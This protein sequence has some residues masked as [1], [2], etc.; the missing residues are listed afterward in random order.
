M[1]NLLVL[2]L[3]ILSG[4]AALLGYALFGQCSPDVVV[5]TAAVAV[6]AMLAMLVDTMIPERF[7]Q[8][9]SFAGLLTVVG[10]LVA[11]VST[12]LTEQ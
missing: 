10:L 6:G 4:I 11:F 2:S 9:H 3:V 7:E 5:A 12:K 1:P 8:A